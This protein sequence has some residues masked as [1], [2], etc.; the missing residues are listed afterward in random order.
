MEEDAITTA[1][2]TS[3]E[4]NGNYAR[5]LFIDY[6]L[7]FN[8]I[9]PYILIR[10]L[11]DLGLSRYICCWMVD[12]LTN[13]LQ[14]VKAQPPPVLHPQALLRLSTNTKDMDEGGNETSCRAEVVGLVTWC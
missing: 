14:T 11:S 9:I 10:N 13:R 8:T 1:L 2:H 4:Q 6:S 3:Q 7:P 12:F 5:M